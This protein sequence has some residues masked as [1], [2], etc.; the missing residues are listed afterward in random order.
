M[1]AG[2]AKEASRL[3]APPRWAP[4]VGGNGGDGGVEEASPSSPQQI[5]PA[6]LPP[7]AWLGE[8]G[9]DGRAP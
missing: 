5:A 3:W 6:P 1:V 4:V 2:L 8:D 9:G 7:T